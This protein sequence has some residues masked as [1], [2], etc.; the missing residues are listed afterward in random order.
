MVREVNRLSVTLVF[1]VFFSSFDYS[2]FCSI[3][4]IF[5][6][7]KISYLWAETVLSR[8]SRS[9]MFFKIGVLNNIANFTGKQLYLSFFLIK[10]QACFPVKLVKFLRT[11]LVT[12]SA[13]LKITKAWL[14]LL[15]LDTR[16]A[17]K[18]AK[19]NSFFTFDPS[20][21]TRLLCRQC[22]KITNNNITCWDLLNKFYM[23]DIWDKGWKLY[24]WIFW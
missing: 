8:S 15:T 7:R 11:P 9:Q 19:H 21:L 3:N 18:W 12:A 10:L 14:L 1:Q 22:C 5:G 6:V 13:Y 16:Q 17:I 2:A 20:L 24:F 23:A 4:T